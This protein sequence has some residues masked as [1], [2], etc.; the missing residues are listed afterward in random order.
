M[1]HYFVVLELPGG[2]E[3]KFV[4]GRN[5]PHRF[6]ETASQTMAMGNA[7]II[8]SREDTGVCEEFRKYITTL[9][10][11]TTFVLV[12]LPLCPNGIVCQSEINKKFKDFLINLNNESVIDA[13]HNF[14]L[15]TIEA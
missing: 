5:S 11:F 14:Q 15:V 10:K 7:L 2:E 13:A 3:L 8:S 12:N 6:W 1:K 9:K 4:N